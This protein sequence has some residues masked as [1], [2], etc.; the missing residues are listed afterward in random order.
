[1][2]R[3]LLSLHRRHGQSTCLS[4]SHTWP[5]PITPFPHKLALRSHALHLGVRC[6][7]RGL[8]VAIA[9]VRA[10]GRFHALV[11]WMS[12]PSAHPTAGPIPTR[13]LFDPHHLRSPRPRPFDGEHV[14][15]SPPVANLHRATLSV[16]H[17]WQPTVVN[18]ACNGYL[19]HSI[20]QAFRQLHLTST[21]HA[22]FHLL[23]SPPLPKRASARPT[24]HPLPHVYCSAH[25]FHLAHTSHTARHLDALQW[26]AGLN[27]RLSRQSWSVRSVVT[28]APQYC[29]CV[30]MLKT[31]VCVCVAVMGVPAG[32]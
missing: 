30:R 14:L 27:A 31:Y 25:P 19:I 10:G 7:S 16:S 12:A 28:L 21:H 9:C 13:V 26:V 5:P 29:R 17:L 11:F 20:V 2:S 6:K 18:D 15:S 32:V 23:L 4:H 24:R 1:V 8:D 22:P 3:P